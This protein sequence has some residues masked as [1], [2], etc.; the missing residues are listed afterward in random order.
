MENDIIA[1]VM[2][3]GK[4]TRMKSKN[5]KLVQKIYG[6]EIVKRAVENAEKAG[7]KDI[8]AVVGYKKEEVM[9]VLGDNIKYAFQDEMLGTG[10][11]V[12]Q[13][14]EYLKGKKGKVLVLNGDVPLIRP[15]TLNKLIEKSIEN[16]E[17][18][19]LLTAIYDDPTGYGRIVR[20]EGGNIEG[21]VEEKD[22]T[23]EQK[24]ITEIN[25]GIYCFD[26]ESY[27]SD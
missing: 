23:E 1:I 13:A 12:M 17:Y 8:V 16:K 4:G 7:V 24:K 10:H 14:K 21:I 27:L 25:A 19:T 3:A 9:K 5:S 18:A 15:E 6:K 22:T 2:A 26:I 20:D 11:A